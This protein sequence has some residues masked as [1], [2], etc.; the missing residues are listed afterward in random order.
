MLAPYGA[1]VTTV[2]H[3]KHIY[4]EYIGVDACAAN[5]MRP[6][7][8]APTTTLLCWARRTPPA[9]ISTM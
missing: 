7:I 8:T 5:P 6:A 1:L 4:K 2:L 9:T 3:Q